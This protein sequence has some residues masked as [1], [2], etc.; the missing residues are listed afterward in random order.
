MNINKIIMAILLNVSIIANC[1][2]AKPAKE[3][4]QAKIVRAI[5]ARRG[6][7]IAECEVQ[8]IKTA[9]NGSVAISG[10]NSDTLL[11]ILTTE[12]LDLMTRGTAAE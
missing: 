10:V 3:C 1:S 4:P 5:A 11:K 6:Y 2:N 7:E 9:A 8:A 12:H